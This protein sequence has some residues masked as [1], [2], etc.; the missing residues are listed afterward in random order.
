MSG[1]IKQLAE[2]ARQKAREQFDDG[3]PMHAGLFSAEKFQEIF[4]ELIVGDC[5]SQIKALRDSK[6]EDAARNNGRS[7]DFAFGVVTA[8]DDLDEDIR[9]HFGFKE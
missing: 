8:C 7:S 3:N 2:Q 1:R 5:L 6:L 9:N 4:A